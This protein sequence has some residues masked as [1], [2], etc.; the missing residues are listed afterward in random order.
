MGNH[1]CVAFLTALAA[2]G[3]G[4]E[5]MSMTLKQR[6][7]EL[8]QRLNLDHPG[9]EKVKA[10]ETSRQRE[11]AKAAL[12]DYYKRRTGPKLSETPPLRPKA[13]V[14]SYDR[15][16]AD[17]V[18]QHIFS[19]I[20]KEVQ[21]GRELDWDVNPVNDVEWTCGF[22]QHGAWVTL[23]RAYW[24]TYDEKYAKEF[25]D[26]LVSWLAAYP[27]LDWRPD[28]KF[29][30]RSTLRA[31]ARA[32]GSWPEAWALFQDS[33]GFTVEARLGM[34][35]SLAQ[36]G[37]FFMT[38]QGG[39]NWLLA[40]SSALAA[41]GILYPEFKDSPLWAK[42]GIDRLHAELDAQI[43]PDGAQVE[44]TPHYHGACMNSFRRAI[45]LATWNAYPLPRDFIGKYEN[46]F[47]CLMY[48][49][50]PD[51]HIPMLNDSDH[52]LIMGWMR[53]GAK[54]FNR[55]D[56]E[57]RAT[58]GKSGSP[59]ERVSIAL[60]YSGFFVMRSDWGADAL[61]LLM[62]V[63]P[64][65]LGHQHEDK[66]GLDVHAYG[67]SHILDPGRFT[68]APGK[69]RQYFLGTEGHS[70]ILVD[71]RG[72]GRRA[73]DRDLWVIQ[74]PL[75][76]Q[77]RSNAQFDFA[78]GSYADGYGPLTDVVHVRKALFVKN[79]YWVVSD[80]VVGA[81]GYTGTHEIQSN[82]QFA[83]VGAKVDPQSKVARS[84]NADANLAIIPLSPE[85][86][87]F[88]VAEGE[89]DPPCGWIGWSYHRNLKTPASMV[90][91]KWKEN[92]PA[93]MDVVLLPYRGREM[94]KVTVKAIES[95]A[96]VTALQVSH[97]RGTDLVLLQH[98][99]PVATAFG[100]FRSDAD[101]ALV[102]LDRGGA[103]AAA[104]LGGGTFLGRDPSP[105][106][107]AAPRPEGRAGAIRVE[108]T[109][110]HRVCVSWPSEAPVR[111][112]VEYGHAGGGGYIFRTSLPDEATKDCRVEIVG[113]T[114]D[115][116]FVY[117]ALAVTDK[118][119]AI[120]GEGTFSL[121]FPREFDFDNGSAE[122]WPTGGHSGCAL[123]APGCGGT[124]S[125]LRCFG[126]VVRDVNYLGA[127][128]ALRLR[129]GEASHVSLAYRTE[130]GGPVKDFYFKVSLT[131]TEGRWWSVYLE[132]LPSPEWKTVELK[133]S[134]FRGDG[135][136][137][138]NSGQT[139]PV[140]AEIRQVGFI[141]R[142][143]A[144]EQPASHSFSVDRIRFVE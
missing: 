49:G 111:P 3:A 9:L 93:S 122:G 4:A 112:C 98:R 38:H 103:V 73:T 85:K 76:N 28:P 97:E 144:T 114:C 22:N 107:V 58:G 102:R 6:E 128:H 108:R 84:N 26:E 126:P 34:L 79:D 15:A 12:L 143:G 134:D 7:D 83:E 87:S 88:R 43:Y 2:F 133:S 29:V 14:G 104:A 141:L 1:I 40:E 140:G 80:R 132:R 17:R 78:A 64:Y 125:C 68:Y 94:P 52:D 75:D 124:G 10:A 19:F 142:K 74:R 113:L 91:Y 37:E 53:D 135:P 129:L 50:K 48:I 61:Y 36:H 137:E 130:V 21:L 55:R 18:L 90:I 20:G 115:L 67:R 39:G 101:V 27:R 32:G 123:V 120:V 25:N 117:R 44:L 11:A 105:T 77:W 46:M 82:F 59:P 47:T 70:T 62:D 63:G 24:Q 96:Q 106:L 31:A 86:F 8:F 72:Q 45:D 41:V 57:F 23:G 30:W 81:H 116:D 69:W 71:G 100:G 138:V 33:A 136:G 89:E 56:F 127:S 92:I 131:D 95:S 35:H 118:G 65:G 54:R 66:L 5:E 110:V 42:T 16:G 60:N 99:P 13:P 121:P 119:E 139:L 109:D 51:G